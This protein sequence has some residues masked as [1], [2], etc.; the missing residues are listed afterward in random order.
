MDL[1]ELL[2]E[3]Y[4]DGMTVEEINEALAK[5]QMPKDNT[6]E[7]DKL[8][9][10][11]SSANSEAKKYKDELKAK[12]SEEELKAKEDAEKWEKLEKERN[13][14]LREKNISTHKAKFLENGYSAE[15]ADASAQALVDGDFDTV[16]K[17]LGVHMQNL[18]KKFKAD[19]IDKTPKPAGGSG[20]APEMTQDQFDAMTYNQR[21]EL[22]QK[23][24]ELYE[25]LSK[26]D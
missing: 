14:L 21:V 6:A 12:L 10:I 13:D 7:I 1:K 4:K 8:K 15:L 23:N 20:K 2:G 5:V 16:F 9:A 22:Y 24:K 11:I 3:Q 18:E 19:N 25:K 26:G 17:N